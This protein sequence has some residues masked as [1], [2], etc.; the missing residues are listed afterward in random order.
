A[1]CPRTPC[2]RR[3]AGARASSRSDRRT[4]RS[5]PPRGWANDGLPLLAPL[6]LFGRLQD[7]FDD[8]VGLD[9]LGFAFEVEDQAVAQRG[10]RDVADVVDRDRVA[11]LEQCADLRG[12]DDRL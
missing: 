1:G 11:A 9:A 8:R 4:A 5:D 3:G 2:A 12:E 10:R 7:L 6:R